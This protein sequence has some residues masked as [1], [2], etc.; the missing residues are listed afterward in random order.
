MS[1][2]TSVTAPVLPATDVTGAP[3]TVVSFHTAA[4]AVASTS[5]YSVSATTS[6]QRDPTA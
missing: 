3:E 2:A 1:A 4:V 6:N 5:T